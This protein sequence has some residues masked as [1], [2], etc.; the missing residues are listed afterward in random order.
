MS[1]ATFD[2]G[3]FEEALDEM[4]SLL[5]ELW[6]VDEAIGLRE[7]ENAG[8]FSFV[9][10]DVGRS[11]PF[12]YTIPFT[13]P[14]PEGG[15]PDL[16]DGGG[17][18]QGGLGNRYDGAQKLVDGLLDIGRE[19]GKEVAAAVRKAVRDQV[20]PVAA[21]FEDA[22]ATMRG[23]VINPLS[24]QIGDDFAHISSSISDW[25]G[26]AADDF[27]NYFYSQVEVSVRNQAFAAESV[28]VGL[29]GAKAIVHLG[30]HSLMGLVVG[31]RDA[32]EQQLKERQAT[33]AVEGFSTSD[34]LLLGAT[35]LALAAAIPTGGASLTVADAAIV[36]AAGTSTLLDF[37]SS[38]VE[39]GESVEFEVSTAEATLES[40]NEHLTDIL[41]RV[42]QHWTDLEETVSQLKTLVAA[43]E[44]E[45]LLYPRRPRQMADGEVSPDQWHHES[46]P[47]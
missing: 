23:S 22:V 40:F 43:A 41:V 26:S 34:F 9:G 1:G 21:S 7:D 37:A 38:Q 29:A 35:F 6:A 42:R 20:R 27:N 3:G 31:A 33:N 44:Q 17:T 36:V 28:C 25:E 45:H 30:Q 13:L 15:V 24:T 5:G 19:W 16:S 46:A 39:D 12:H 18:G 47:R 32:I 10:V 4:G 11:Y 2:R 8:P 14:E